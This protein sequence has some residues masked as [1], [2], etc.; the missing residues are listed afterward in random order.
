MSVNRVAFVAYEP[1]ETRVAS[2]FLTRLKEEDP[3]LETLLIVADPFQIRNNRGS[4]RLRKLAESASHRT[5]V[6]FED[7]LEWHK[8]IPSVDQRDALTRVE[9]IAKS[10]GIDYLDAVMSSDPHLMPR[11]RAP[12]YHPLTQAE[13]NAASVLVFEK[14]LD[15]LDA[16]APDV[17]VM[18]W[19]QYLVKNFVGAVCRARNIPVRVFRRVRYKDYLKLDYFFLPISQEPGES[20]TAPNTK[21]NL[22]AEIE[23]FGNSLYPNNLAVTEAGFVEQCHNAP[24]KAIGQVLAR[25]WKAQVRK[26]QTGPFS[27]PRKF[28]WLRY[29]VSINRRVHLYLLMKVFRSFR[30]IFDRKTLTGEGAL[31]ERFV[32]VPLHFR[33]ESAILTQGLGTEDDDV[34]EQVARTLKGIDPEV[35]C[36]VLEH[37]SMIEDRRY[38]F[39]RKLKSWGNVVIADPVIPTQ[40][41]IQRSLGVITISGTV[42]LEASIAG[43][44]VHVAGYPE[45][46]GA[47]Q[48]HGSEALQAFLTACAN[49]E[50][51]VSGEGA[52]SYLEKHCHEGWQGDLGWAAIK[53]EEALE[54][55]VTTLREMFHASTK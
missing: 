37:P 17:V 41:L 52:L 55:T 27:R 32:V 49:D 40:E 21:E 47:I 10:E 39:Y 38:A 28:R 12:F 44:P 26:L 30:Y 53:S 34:V 5:A 45:Y 51:P 50:G 42:G 13:K 22:R 35:A 2:R 29:W 19:D 54:E 1:W 43:I 6:I 4:R 14:V 33:P 31:P 46:L 7:L 24:L 20:L 8:T 9:T 16:F 36:V 15:T 48:S 3:S 25:G 11:E 18:M 23:A